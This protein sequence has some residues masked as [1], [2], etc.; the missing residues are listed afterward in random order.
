MQ[1]ELN[2][3]DPAGTTL[4]IWESSRT[5]DPSC[6]KGITGGPLNGMTDVNPVW[7]LRKLTEL[8]GP[9]G[10]GWNVREV[11]RWTHEAAGETAAFVKVELRINLGG[12]WSEPIE[13]TGGS[14]LVRKDKNGTTLSDEAW[15]M[16]STDAIS[17]ACKSLGLAAD[18]YLGV[19]RHGAARQGAPDYGTKYEGRNYAQNPPQGSRPVSSTP[20]SSYGRQAAPQTPPPPTYGPGPVVASTGAPAPQYQSG[21]VEVNPN[22]QGRIRIQLS[23]VTTGRCRKIITALSQHDF[24]DV[25][26]WNA[27]VRAILDKYDVDEDA[28]QEI[29]T[30][31]VN[32]RIA[33][34]DAQAVQAYNDLP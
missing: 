31:A 19:Q 23:T 18:V 20:R 12:T 33:R 28:L 2:P 4:S 30:R 8:F 29:N 32:E 6:L 22:P 3:Q 1:K 7:R 11:E 26:D 15:K 10:F 16:A 5:V 13:G 27:G 21:P 17:V 14:K 9:V 34:H 24:D 25:D